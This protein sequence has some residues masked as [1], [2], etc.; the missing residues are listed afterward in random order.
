V[1]RDRRS[2]SLRYHVC[3]VNS[4]SKGVDFST[5]WDTFGLPKSN[6]EQ[7]ATVNG[8]LDG[9]KA[10]FF[11]EMDSKQKLFA[12]EII[13]LESEV[14][15]FGQYVDAGKIRLVA[16]KAKQIQKRIDDCIRRAREYNA[17]EGH[18]GRDTTDYGNVRELSK[19]FAPYYQLWTSSH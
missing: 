3:S 19:S 11:D 8:F 18:F 10:V 1:S 17:N 14:N 2:T 16:E 5:R 12:A 9:Q 13:S 4:N 6:A 7:V 15:D